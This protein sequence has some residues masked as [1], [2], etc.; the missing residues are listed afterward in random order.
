M[1]L[2]ICKKKHFGALLE[3]HTKGDLIIEAQVCKG[4]G[5]LA[6]QG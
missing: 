6:Q 1:K 4:Q 3:A 5:P 2:V